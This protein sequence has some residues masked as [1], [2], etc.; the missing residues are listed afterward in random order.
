MAF[1]PRWQPNCLTETVD[2]CPL[3]LFDKD[4]SQGQGLCLEACAISKMRQTIVP[5]NVSTKGQTSKLKMFP[6]RGKHLHWKCF[7]RGANIYIENVSTEGANIYMGNVSTEGANI[8]IENV[9]TEGQTS[10]LKMFP[11]LFLG[12]RAGK[13]K[14][15]ELPARLKQ[16]DLSQ[17]GGEG[18]CI[19]KANPPYPQLCYR[20]RSTHARKPTTRVVSFA[21]VQRLWQDPR[22]IVRPAFCRCLPWPTHA[23]K[24]T[25]R[26]VSFAFV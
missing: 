19:Y 14:P 21:L 11:Y 26:V 13:N 17:N 15:R 6:Q 7:H 16:K 10:T 23:R 20:K 2:K 22:V 24:P 3:H 5:G 8:Y 12:R 1:M 9:S 4:L 25:T 18:K